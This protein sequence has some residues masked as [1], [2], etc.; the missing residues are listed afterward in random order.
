M[1]DRNC[2]QS[3]HSFGKLSPQPWEGDMLNLKSE[4]HLDPCARAALRHMDWQPVRRLVFWPFLIGASI[5]VGLVLF[6][7]WL[8]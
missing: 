2:L 4:A 5:G 7:A 6:L 3:C 1:T 8:G